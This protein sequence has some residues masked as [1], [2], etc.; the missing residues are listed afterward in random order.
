M[1]PGTDARRKPDIALLLPWEDIATEGRWWTHPAACFELKWRSSKELSPK[2]GASQH[3][4][5]PELDL[6]CQAIDGLHYL[7]RQPGRVHALGVTIGNVTTRFYF[8]SSSCVVISNPIQVD[9]RT[10]AT[11]PFAQRSSSPPSLVSPFLSPSTSLE[12]HLSIQPS[13]A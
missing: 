1:F 8:A 11:S 2:V 4:T 12:K 7:L 3:A 13:Y 10:F 6:L 9:D 5:T